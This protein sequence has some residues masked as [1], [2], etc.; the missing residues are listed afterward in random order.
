MVLPSLY[1][2][3]VNHPTNMSGYRTDE[4]SYWGVVFNI[5]FFYILGLVYSTNR[6]IYVENKSITNNNFLCHVN[7]SYTSS[8]VS[9]TI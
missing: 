8:M 1:L 5:K 7:R 4:I 3:N 9:Y 2:V 6:L